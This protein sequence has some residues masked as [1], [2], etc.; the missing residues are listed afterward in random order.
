[1]H[2]YVVSMYIHVSVYVD[3]RFMVCSAELYPV[4]PCGLYR[5][6]VLRY[7]SQGLQP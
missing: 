1:M 5:W 6:H 4:V 3:S 7:P 2:S